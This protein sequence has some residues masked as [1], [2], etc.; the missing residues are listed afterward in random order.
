MMESVKQNRLLE[1]SRVVPDAEYR[2]D[3]VGHVDA[4]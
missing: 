4:S 3:I 2:R 1:V